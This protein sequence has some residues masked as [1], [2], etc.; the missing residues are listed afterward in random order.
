M[1]TT[2]HISEKDYIR[3][4]KLSAKHSIFIFVIIAFIV[5][6]FFLFLY[7][8]ERYELALMVG[9]ALL[10]WGIICFHLLNPILW[11]RH[12][13]KYKMLQEPITIEL[14][15]NDQLFLTIADSNTHI[16]FDKMLKWRQ[17]KDF[18]LIYLMPRLFYVIPKRLSETGFDIDR[19]IAL[20]TKHLGKAT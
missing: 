7:G 10:G 19:L 4:V 3:A 18:I 15:Q 1:K 20:L 8:K 11:K 14:D 12:Y 17:N 2:F 13:R 6:L 16:D 9:A 5:A